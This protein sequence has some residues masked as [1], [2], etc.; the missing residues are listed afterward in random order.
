MFIILPVKGCG[1]E[2]GFGNACILK[3]DS[4]K[5]RQHA[6]NEDDLPEALIDLQAGSQEIF[7]N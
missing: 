6:V 2:A 5:M 3:K 1:R 7:G 4:A